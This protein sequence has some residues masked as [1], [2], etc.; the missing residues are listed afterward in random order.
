MMKSPTTNHIPFGV[1]LSLLSLTVCQTASAKSGAVDYSWGA[2]GLAEATSF[3]GT[4]MIYTVDV[5]YA[6]AAVMVIVSA[7]QIYIKMNNH[8]G[9]ITKSIMMLFGG[10]PVYDRSDD[11]HA[12]LL[13]LSEHEFHILEYCIREPQ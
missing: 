8:E 4:M 1:F 11:S 3:V 5:L 6:V 10:H 9:D 2:D 12:S 7:L 13:R